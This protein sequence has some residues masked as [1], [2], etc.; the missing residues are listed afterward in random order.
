MGV[1]GTSARSL[2]S[3]WKPRS[4]PGTSV[5]W[6]WMNSGWSPQVAGWFFSGK[7]PLKMDDDRGISTFVETS[8]HIHIYLYIYILYVYVCIY[9]YINRYIENHGSKYW[10][11][12]YLRYDLGCQVF[13]Q[14]G[15]SSSRPRVGEPAKLPTKSSG[16]VGWVRYFKVVSLG[17]SY[18]FVFFFWYLGV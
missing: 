9:I 3:W 1:P 15:V 7:I 8:I 17:L 2:K 4:K 10:L 11:R 13:S 16:R 12:K 18:G 5:S 6:R 14:T